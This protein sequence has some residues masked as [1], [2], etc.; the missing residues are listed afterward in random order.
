[1]DIP[2][3]WFEINNPDEVDSPA[4]IIHKNR[5]D[6]NIRKMIEL[7]DVYG[8]CGFYDAL[9]PETKEVAYK[10][11]ALDQGMIFIALNNYLNDNAIVKRFMKDKINKD[12][13]RVLEV[14]K[15]FE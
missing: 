13:K 12:V 6:H 2:K 8:E 4:L 10:Y 7:Y 3:A 14:E 5:V 11:L 1:M 9:N 15:F